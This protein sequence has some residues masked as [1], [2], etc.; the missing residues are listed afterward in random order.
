MDSLIITEMNMDVGD[1]YLKFMYANREY[2][3]RNNHCI[4]TD[5]EDEV[6]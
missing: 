4:C 1:P 6:N 2:S 5:I 3:I